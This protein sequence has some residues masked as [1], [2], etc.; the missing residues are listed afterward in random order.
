[1]GFS[2]KLGLLS[3]TIVKCLSAGS[4]AR[5]RICTPVLQITS[6]LT[7][8]NRYLIVLVL[9]LTYLVYTSFTNGRYLG[10]QMK[11]LFLRIFC[12]SVSAMKGSLWYSALSTAHLIFRPLIIVCFSSPSSLWIWYP[13]QH[14]HRYRIKAWLVGLETP[15]LIPSAGPN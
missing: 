2:L 9:F 13:R 6:I 10:K 1:M 15:Q 7:L 3:G 4:Q 11:Y 12:A 5:P 8:R 14:Q